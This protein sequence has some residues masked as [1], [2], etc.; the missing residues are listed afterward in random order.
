MWSG[1]EERERLRAALRAALAEAVE[2]R[3]E[4][5]VAA[6]A[7]AEPA[8]PDPYDRIRSS[9][10]PAGKSSAWR[11]SSPAIDTG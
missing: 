5:R 10:S 3:V 7:W 11:R 6:A 8:T 4:W 9:S 1:R 2:R